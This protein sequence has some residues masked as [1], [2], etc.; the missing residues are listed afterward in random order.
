MS[1]KNLKKEF[2]KI[3]PE[4][5]RKVLCLCSQMAEK[6]SLRLFLIGGVVRDIIIC[7]EDWALP[8]PQVQVAETI[9]SAQDIIA[10][11]RAVSV[12]LRNRRDQGF[13][14]HVIKWLITPAS[15]PALINPS[16][17]FYNVMHTNHAEDLFNSSMLHVCEL[18]PKT[19]CTSSKYSLFAM[20]P[21]LYSTEFIR[22]IWKQVDPKQ[23][24]NMNIEVY[25]YLNI[26][27]PANFQVAFGPG[28][29]VHNRL[30]R[31]PP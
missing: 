3:V 6:L 14:S 16:L 27:K 7:E 26:W 29:F 4:K 18:N 31:G 30:D 15:G 8:I 22:S 17:W 20:A 2:E 24:K 9:L 13:P 10:S 1:N 5:V 12:Q 25:I 28:I 21:Q 11:G 23:Y 19:W